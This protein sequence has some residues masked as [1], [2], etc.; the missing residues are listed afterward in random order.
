MA[1]AMRSDDI[2]LVYGRERNRWL[3]P[4]DGRRV[5]LVVSACFSGSLIDSLSDSSRIILTAAAKA[6]S[7]STEQIYMLTQ[8]GVTQSTV[9]SADLD[10][11]SSTRPSGKTTAR[12]A[13]T[14]NFRWFNPLREVQMLTPPAKATAV[15][16][17]LKLSQRPK[18]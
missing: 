4:P 2:A 7:L 16:V 15:L 14:L 13:K 18:M 8:V 17:K 1:L 3:Q 10:W 11:G 6:P 12:L 5:M 9:A